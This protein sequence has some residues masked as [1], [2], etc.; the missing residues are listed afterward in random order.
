MH[1]VVAPFLHDSWAFSLST[2]QASDPNVS[3]VDPAVVLSAF[4]SVKLMPQGSHATEATLGWESFRLHWV[5]LCHITVVTSDGATEV[6][7]NSQ[8]G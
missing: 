8:R 4:R 7:V 3:W 6:L 2:G 1:A 5:N